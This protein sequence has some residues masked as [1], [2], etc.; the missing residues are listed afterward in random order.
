MMELLAGFVSGIPRLELINVLG[1]SR[2]LHCDVRYDGEVSA[3][4]KRGGIA[5][6]NLVCTRSMT[7]GPGAGLISGA[8][9]ELTGSSGAKQMLNI[10]QTIHLA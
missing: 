10:N 7:D 8:T 4:P 6:G 1:D 3:L 2:I 5:E 9:D